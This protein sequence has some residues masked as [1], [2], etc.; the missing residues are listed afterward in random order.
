MRV[1]RHPSWE[2]AGPMQFAPDKGELRDWKLWL[3]CTQV[4]LH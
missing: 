3:Y 1:L 4:G 2:A